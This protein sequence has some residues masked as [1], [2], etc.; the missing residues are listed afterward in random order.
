MNTSENFPTPGILFTDRQQRASANV[1]IKAEEAKALQIDPRFD[2]LV[3]AASEAG[4]GAAIDFDGQSNLATG[5]AR[6]DIRLLNVTSSNSRSDS[7]EEVTGSGNFVYGFEP[8]HRN[9]VGFKI[10]RCA[11]HKDFLKEQSASFEDECQDLRS[12]AAVNCRGGSMLS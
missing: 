1:P 12:S 4:A 9:Y 6:L 11:G 10:R 7:P 3:N 2:R 5:L 8:A